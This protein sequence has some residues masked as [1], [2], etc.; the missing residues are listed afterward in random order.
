LVNIIRVDDFCSA[1][2]IKRIDLMKIDVEGYE[3]NVL[4][5]AKQI[6]ERDIP[7][8]FIEVDDNNLAQQGH[9]AREILEFLEPK[10]KLI[11]DAATH[12]SISANDNFTNCHFDLVARK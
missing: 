7:D 9:S 2:Q 5:G 3:M 10:Y 6:I 12:K 8:L 1:Q 4:L 11:Y